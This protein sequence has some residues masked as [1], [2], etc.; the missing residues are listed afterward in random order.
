MTLYTSKLKPRESNEFIANTLS[1]DASSKSAALKRELNEFVY[2]VKFNFK[3][4]ATIVY[5]ICTGEPQ[6][7]D[8]I[9]RAYD[10]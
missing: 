1:Q 8:A 6:K 7:I 3:S 9:S 4:K 10:R 2:R 5:I